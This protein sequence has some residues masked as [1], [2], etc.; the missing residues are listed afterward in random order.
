[1]M[2]MFKKKKK[3]KDNT[4]Y[5]KHNI[6]R[7]VSS[8]ILSQHK[9]LWYFILQSWSYICKVKKNVFDEQKTHKARQQ[10]P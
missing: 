4:F 6:M 5:N 9:L 10:E 2:S 3:I 7:R 8:L 1:M